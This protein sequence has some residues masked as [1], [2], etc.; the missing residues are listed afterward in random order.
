[1][2]QNLL[3][4]NDDCIYK[5][6]DF[7]T[8]DDLCS[9]SQTC[10]KLHVLCADHF[11]RKYPNEAKKEVRMEIEDNE[12]NYYA[13]NYC[14]KYFDNFIKNVKIY[15]DSK[16]RFDK[17]NEWAARV[18][19]FFLAK[20]DTKL[21]RICI[22][23]HVEL[24][25]W[26]K[27]IENFLCNVEVVEFIDE[28][29]RGQDMVTLLQFCPNVKKLI[30]NE[31][32]HM[33]N[34]DAVLGRKYEQ[35]THFSYIKGSVLNLNPEQLKI[36][37][38]TNHQLQCVTLKFT[39]VDN[40]INLITSR[41]VKCIETMTTNA[42]Y[43]EHLFLNI[44]GQ[45]AQCFDD[46]CSQ[47]NVLC[48][49][50]H[51]KSLVIRFDYEGGANALKLY[52]SH[53]ANWKQL[54]KIYLMRIRLIDVIPALRSLVHLK[55][56]VLTEDGW[57]CVPDTNDMPNFN[58]IIDTVV[59]TQH[60]SLPQ[61]EEVLIDHMKNGIAIL[62]LVMLFTRHW[63]N[64]KRVL[65]PSNNFIVQFDIGELI[66]ARKKLAN[67]CDVTIFTNCDGNPTNLDHKLMK[68]KN[69]QFE[70]DAFDDANLFQRWFM[71]SEK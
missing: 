31:C 5:I 57:F 20:C 55:M 61:V 63:M 12:I 2:I 52:S 15:A 49:R 36:F 1:M 66:R 45:I 68:L 41:T 43:L 40:D 64:L 44:G 8:L 59:G 10:Q 21:Y 33:E 6:L 16:C 22:K 7:L 56:I 23:G 19:T 71:A 13:Q 38:E 32:I 4:I 54:T 34:V 35:L 60:F 50:D 29:K 53:M 26:C 11:R 25:P 69:V 46:V 27:E 28:S 39:N 51:F 67:A 48:E 37:H 70:Y 42:T 62:N 3:T 9:F 18:T 24:V 14:L 30:L 47:L 58:E 65:V 17:S